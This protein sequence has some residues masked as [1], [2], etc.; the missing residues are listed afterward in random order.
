MTLLFYLLLLINCIKTHTFIINN[1]SHL[2]VTFIFLSFLHHVL[3]CMPS[4]FLDIFL[5]FPGVIMELSY[6][7]IYFSK[8]LFNE[9]GYYYSKWRIRGSKNSSWLSKEISKQK[10]LSKQK[11]SGKALTQIQ[12]SRLF[13]VSYVCF[14]YSKCLQQQFAIYVTTFCR[15]SLKGHF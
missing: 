10:F 8:I 5:H 6:F 2:I 11:F 14:S 13:V 12:F 15:S 7:V 9:R 3:H 1:Y 4:Y